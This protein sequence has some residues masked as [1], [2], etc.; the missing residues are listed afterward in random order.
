MT[1]VLFVCLLL[2]LSACNTSRD[3]A[4]PTSPT[5]V[6]ASATP[7]INGG[8]TPFVVNRVPSPTPSCA[9]APRT[10]LIVGERGQVSDDDTQVL[11]VREGPGREFTVLATLDVYDIFRVLEGPQC[12]GPY[13]W[14]RVRHND[15]EGW[16][17]EGDFGVY[18]V[19]PYLP[20]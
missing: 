9:A 13:V 11:N 2:I 4:S 10:R 6:T 14:Y 8:M 7:T 15:L 18:Y 3:P 12:S 20:G 1:R 5:P 17:A 19:E 16:I